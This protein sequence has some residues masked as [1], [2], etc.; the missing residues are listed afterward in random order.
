[1]GEFYGLEDI[2]LLDRKIS[3]LQDA[4]SVEGLYDF[5]EREEKM[6]ILRGLIDLF[7]SLQL[8]YDEDDNNG[9]DNGEGPVD[10][11]QIKLFLN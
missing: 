8:S 1:M 10:F 4:L 5:D 3:I 11:Y 7:L 6:E 2:E 9:D